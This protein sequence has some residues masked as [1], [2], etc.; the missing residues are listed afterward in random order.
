MPDWLRQRIADLPLIEKS[1]KLS[2]KRIKKLKDEIIQSKTKHL[3][4]PL[5]SVSYNLIGP[6][7]KGLSL[8]MS[9]NNALHVIKENFP[10]PKY[11]PWEIDQEDA[12][13]I[14]GD[15]RLIRIHANQYKQVVR[16]VFLSTNS[17]FNSSDLSLEE[18]AQNI[19]DNYGIPEMKWSELKYQY[20]QLGKTFEHS[21]KNEG[22]E[23]KI[24]SGKKIELKQIPKPL[25]HSFD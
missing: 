11:K 12:N 5:P 13:Y 4:S 9:L 16:I 19:M 8:G 20:L 10:A 2:N 6:K 18:F 7:I 14:L 15:N 23:I 1:I 25:K 22:W 3:A 17:I 24:T 21:N